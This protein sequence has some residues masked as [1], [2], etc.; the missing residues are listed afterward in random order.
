MHKPVA[1]AQV[2]CNFLIPSPPNM[3]SSFNVSPSFSNL[4]GRDIHFLSLL[5][6]QFG[7]Y[8]PILVRI[9][10]P[11]TEIHDLLKAIEQGVSILHSLN[12]TPSPHWSFVGTEGLWK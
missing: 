12:P 4:A 3:G 6:G 7:P 2:E 1:N 10:P 9:G 8:W 5:H 11:M